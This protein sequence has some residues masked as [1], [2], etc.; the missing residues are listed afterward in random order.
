VKQQAQGKQLETPSYDSKHTSKYCTVCTQACS[1]LGLFLLLDSVRGTS[2]CVAKKYKS[3]WYRLERWWTILTGTF[4][5]FHP[6]HSFN[7]HSLLWVLGTHF[8]VVS[9]LSWFF[10]WS[11]QIYF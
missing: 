2:Q 3:L 7:L 8:T 4:F 10:G 5:R 11:R 1:A 6:L 9:N